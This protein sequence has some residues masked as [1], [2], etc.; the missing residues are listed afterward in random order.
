MS[1][2]HWRQ[3]I[4]LRLLHWVPKI[5]IMQFHGNCQFFHLISSYSFIM[6]LV[7]SSEN[8]SSV[9]DLK[10]AMYCPLLYLNQKV[11]SPR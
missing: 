9:P 5:L 4:K 2:I 11:T 3:P 8:F 6:H 7:V 1:D 10:I